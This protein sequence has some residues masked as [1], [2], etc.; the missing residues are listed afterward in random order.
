M[1]LAALLLAQ[2]AP[3]T[4]PVCPTISDAGLP[5]TLAGWR[6]SAG[7]LASAKAVTLPSVDPKTVRLA[8]VPL[9]K[10]VGRMALTTFVVRRAGTYGIALDQKGWIDLYRL[11]SAAAL[12][13]TRH[14]HGPDCSTIRKIVRFT[15]TPGSYRVVLSGLAQ[16]SAKL[17]LVKD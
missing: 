1:I 10:E 17:M 11:G 9:P 15:L 16:P 4:A 2:A 12:V 7:D 5:A 6:Q 8:D 13:S 14:G 3:A